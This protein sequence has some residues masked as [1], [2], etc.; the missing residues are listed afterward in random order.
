MKKWNT[1]VVEELNIAE[2]ANGCLLSWDE[3]CLT[4]DNLL[5]GCDKG[6]NGTT[7]TEDDTDFAS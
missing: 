1:P 2:T 4:N 3:G 7:D 5:G 6:D